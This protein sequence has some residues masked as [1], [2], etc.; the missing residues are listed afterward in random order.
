M[1]P[2]TAHDSRRIALSLEG[3]EESSQL[4]QPDFRVGGKIFATLASEDQGY[5]NLK[6]SPEQTGR[7]RRRP[8]A[9]LHSYSGRL[10]KDGYNTHTTER[11]DGRRANWCI[12]NCLEIRGRSECEE[13]EAQAIKSVA[14]RRTIN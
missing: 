9:S 2:L 11:S 1:Q 4:G 13:R 3:A 7:V 10:G 6:L 12:A 14:D 5:G 8:S